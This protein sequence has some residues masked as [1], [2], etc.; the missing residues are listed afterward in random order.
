MT[1][2]P[3]GPLPDHT[4]DA[5]P[6]ADPRPAGADVSATP[7][8]GWSA[9][10]YGRT[11]R[12]DQWWRALP[13]GVDRQGPLAEAVRTA[14]AGGDR[15]EDGPRFVFHRDEHGVLLG[16]AC[17]FGLISDTMVRDKFDR[18][19]YG[20]V[21]WYSEAPGPGR[22]PELAEL[23]DHLV[24]WGGRVY[25]DWTA[26]T[27]EAADRREAEP[28]VTVPVA[29]PWPDRAPGT[30][31]ELP[32]TGRWRPARADG[33]HL[34]PESEAGALWSAAASVPDPCLLVTGWRRRTDADIARL[35]HL[36]SRDGRAYELLFRPPPAPP[37]AT[38]FTPNQAAGD[39]TGPAASGSGRS[40]RG[41]SKP[42]RSKAGTFGPGAPYPSGPGTVDPAYG[43][44]GGHGGYDGYGGGWRGAVHGA[45]GAGH[46]GPRPG[47]GPDPAEPPGQSVLG[48][49]LG[50]AGR[51][52]TEVGRKV[53]SA[54]APRRRN[55]GRPADP[56]P[57]TAP[58]DPYAEVPQHGAPHGAPEGEAHDDGRPYTGRASGDDY[59]SPGP[60]VERPLF[61]QTRSVTPQDA[62]YSG[63]FGG[64]DDPEP[65]VTPSGPAPG[66]DASG[67][68]SSVPS[69]GSVPAPPTVPPSVALP[70][71]PADPPPAPP[72]RPSGPP[73][74]GS[75][76]PADRRAN[77]PADPGDR[78]DSTTGEPS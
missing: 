61:G 76:G 44:H 10:V 4:S 18:P 57:D 56:Y 5:T 50:Q 55:G 68:P 67:A 24:P 49:L 39:P 74:G 36:T 42:G 34:L 53:D 45:G 43:G 2:P 25:R 7:P 59:V 1:N 13:A 62:D 52:L 32:P 20:F 37:T 60:S 12:I 3:Y 51:F 38:R 71:P 26:P 23:E 8:G 65:P 33:A 27:W 29:A 11:L 35:T 31:G 54:L 40:K 14:V 22:L 77:P 78:T 6:A 73:P 48:Q 21:G 28:Q 58:R 41:P 75:A 47:K 72:R 9:V 63:R 66:P 17:E 30:V 15:L 19:L 69:S 70:D 46:D 64:F 16:A